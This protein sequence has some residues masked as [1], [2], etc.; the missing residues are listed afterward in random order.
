MSGGEALQSADWSVF[1]EMIFSHC[2][3]AGRQVKRIQSDATFAH[4]HNQTIRRLYF[5]TEQASIKRVAVVGTGVIGASWIA[6]FLAQGLDV[7]A[8][9]PMPGAEQKLRSA[10]AQYW[11]TLEAL[12]LKPGASPERLRLSADLAEALRDVDFVQENGPEREDLKVELF[13][14]MDAM[15]PAHVI[16]ASSSSGLLMSKVQAACRYPQRVVLGHP[17]NPPHL[18]P[19]V[20]A[21]GGAQTSDELVAL[22]ICSTTSDRLSKVGGPIWVSPVSLMHSSKAFVPASKNR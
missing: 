14:T 7:S 18:I 3:A 1:V 21:I 8:S 11:P 2:Q 19:L 22:P 16:L 13:R 9:D 10:I 4:H 17:F 5:M 15:L 20:E 12:G 6:Y